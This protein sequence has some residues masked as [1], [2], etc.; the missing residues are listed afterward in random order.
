MVILLYYF[1]S[2][3]THYE[4]SHMSWDNP[5]TLSVLWESEKKTF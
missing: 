5:P 4:A 2:R 1:K 3:Q